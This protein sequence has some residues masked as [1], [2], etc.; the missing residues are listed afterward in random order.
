MHRIYNR[1]LGVFTTLRTVCDTKK[2]RIGT[3]ILLHRKTAART[4]V[5]SIGNT[6][7][8]FLKVVQAAMEKLKK[9]LLKHMDVA[10]QARVLDPTQI[11]S[12]SHD[13][14]QYPHVIPSELCPRIEQSG[15]WKLYLDG[16]QPTHRNWTFWDGARA[17]GNTCLCCTAV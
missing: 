2:L 9:Y 10:R 3:D 15:E 5:Y 14:S 11:R 12:I 6:P 13:I 7:T 1:M 4:N 8:Q 16:V 17:C